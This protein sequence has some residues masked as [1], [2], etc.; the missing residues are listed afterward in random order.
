MSEVVQNK[1]WYE[2]DEEAKV[3]YVIKIL[4]F[5]EEANVITRLRL[6]RIYRPLGFNIA[7][8]TELH[9][10]VS[11]EGS[12]ITVTLSKFNYSWNGTGTEVFGSVTVTEK[13]AEEDPWFVDP[14]EMDDTVEELGVAKTC[15]LILDCIKDLADYYLTW[16]E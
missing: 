16:D 6:S 12:Q 13:Y 9:Y 10:D 1:E 2:R 15:E 4:D 7:N 14:E 11:Y 3:E 8:R 5:D